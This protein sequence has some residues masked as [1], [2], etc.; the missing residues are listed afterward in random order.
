MH[1]LVNNGCLPANNYA[2]SCL[3]PLNCN[4][5]PYSP[6]P[7]YIECCPSRTSSSGNKVKLA[8]GFLLFSS[9]VIQLISVCKSSKSSCALRKPCSGRLSFLKKCLCSYFCEE[10]IPS[11]PPA[12]PCLTQ[13]PCNLFPSPRDC[14]PNCNQ[15][16]QNCRAA[17]SFNCPSFVR[18]ISPC[19]EGCSFKRPDNTAFLP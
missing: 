10:T 3:Y 6:P 5:P 8:L 17:N 16:F 14:F 9:V 12:V 1:K 13:S 2:S 18:R 15:P 19:S 7:Q 4:N 11:K